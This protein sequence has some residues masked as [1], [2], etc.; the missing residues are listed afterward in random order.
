[1]T[2]VLILGNSIIFTDHISEIFLDQKKDSCCDAPYSETDLMFALIVMTNGRKHRISKQK[3]Y[4]QDL[5][6]YISTL[7]NLCSDGRM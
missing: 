1:M 7:N 2:N 4:Y 5:L 3:P 6:D